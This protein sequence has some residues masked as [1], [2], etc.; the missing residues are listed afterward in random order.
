MDNQQY[1]AGSRSPDRS[2]AHSA[3]AATQLADNKPQIDTPIRVLIPVSVNA[4][5]RADRLS[6]DQHIRTNAFSPSAFAT[7]KIMVNSSN[8]DEKTFLPN[9]NFI[10]DQDAQ[11]QTAIRDYTVLAFSSRR[12]GKKEVEASAYVSIAVILDNQ[13]HFEQV[14]RIEFELHQLLSKYTGS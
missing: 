14:L 4:P 8:P 1:E 6:R 12:A 2:F 10:I 9:N 11:L 13:G 3:E 7:M 5:Q